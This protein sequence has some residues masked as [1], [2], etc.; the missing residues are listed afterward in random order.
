MAKSGAVSPRGTIPGFPPALRASSGLLYWASVG[1]S[2]GA[3]SA[4]EAYIGTR[5]SLRAGRGARPV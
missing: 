3:K 4:Y 5:G 2:D 1:L